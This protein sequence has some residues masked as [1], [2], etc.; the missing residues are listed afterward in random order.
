MANPWESDNFDEV[1]AYYSAY[2]IPQ[3]AALWCG[4]PVEVLDQ[5]LSQ[6]TVT[7][8]NIYAHPKYLVLNQYAGRFMMLSTTINTHAAGMARDA[9]LNQKI[10]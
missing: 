10:M 5:I 4:V 6:A 2:Y 8:N 9:N 3:A 7:G 1:K